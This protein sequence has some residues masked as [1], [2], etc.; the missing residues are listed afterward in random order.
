MAA[1]GGARRGAL[2]SRSPTLKARAPSDR[3]LGGRIRLSLKINI[4]LTIGKIYKKW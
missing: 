4:S 1:C 2:A 3:N